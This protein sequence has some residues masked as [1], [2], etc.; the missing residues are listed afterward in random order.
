MKYIATIVIAFEDDSL[1]RAAT[2]ASEMGE[3]ACEGLDGAYGDSSARVVTTT[4][5]HYE[6]NGIS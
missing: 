1:E 2:R 4:S 6:E 3:W 5:S